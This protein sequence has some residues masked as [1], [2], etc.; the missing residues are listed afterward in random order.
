MAGIE[1]T[2]EARQTGEVLGWSRELID[3]GLR[4]AVDTLPAAMRHITGYHFGWWDEHG[5]PA[6]S[7]GGK[8]IR[9]ALVLLAAEAVGGEPAAAVPAAVAVELIHNFSLVHDDIMDGDVTRRHRPTAWTVYGLGAAILAG[10]AMQTLAFDTLAGIGHPRLREAGRMLTATVLDLLEG[11]NADV[12]FERRHDVGLA[13]CLTMA[14]RKTGALLGCSCA[15]GALLAGGTAEQVAHLG[16]FGR[17]LGLAF[18]LT[19]DLLGIWGDPAVTGKPVHSDLRSRKKS[20][21][22]VAALTSGSEAG[23]ELAALYRRDTPL[24]DAEPA[25]GAQLIEAAGG[26]S[27]SRARA[28][29]L[30]AKALHHLRSARPAGRAAGELEALAR[31][32]T[33]RDR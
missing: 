19:D 29:E 22:V 9:P 11:Q 15:L 7:D 28:D 2:A 5:T 8:A 17:L 4:R 33:R 12:S 32:A 27:W 14:E 31:L 13:E 20:L 30:L 24:T 25:R 10:D 23:A 6:E 3:P 1:M 21:P 18:Q 16:D 26:R